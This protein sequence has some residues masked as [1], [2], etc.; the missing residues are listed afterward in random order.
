LKIVH[1]GKYLILLRNGMKPI[2]K[3]LLRK[4]ISAL[5]S[6]LLNI[7]IIRLWFWSWIEAMSLI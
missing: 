2:L 4:Y 7:N 5:S 6:F 3:V 1:I